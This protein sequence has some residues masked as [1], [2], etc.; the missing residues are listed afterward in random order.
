VRSRAAKTA[1]SRISGLFSPYLLR[2]FHAV[3]GRKIRGRFPGALP[4]SP[5]GW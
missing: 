4:R 1:N 5:A 3:P 2:Y